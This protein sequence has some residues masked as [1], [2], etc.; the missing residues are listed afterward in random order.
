MK[1]YMRI[2]AD[3][4]AFTATQLDA[5]DGAQPSVEHPNAAGNLSN[6]IT[7]TPR[8]RVFCRVV[9]TDGANSITVTVESTAVVAEGSSGNLTVEDPVITIAHDEVVML[10]PWSTN[11]EQ[12][13]PNVGK[14][15]LT[16]ACGSVSEDDVDVEVY[17]IV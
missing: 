13:S 3:D 10:G 7:N 12:A 2:L 14:V 5:I 9:N 6:L 16:W 15:R 8:G 1:K 4:V 17:K 11:F